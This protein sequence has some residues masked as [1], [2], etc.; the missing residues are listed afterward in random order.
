[1][2]GHAT[3]RSLYL[4]REHKRLKVRVAT[5]EKACKTALSYLEESFPAD[6]AI[7]TK[8]ALR[9]ALAK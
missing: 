8:R 6:Q 5:L 2:P 9:K 3:R 1:M 4:S 7:H